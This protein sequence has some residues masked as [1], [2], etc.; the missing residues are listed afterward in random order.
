MPDLEITLTLIGGPTLLIELA[1][2]GILTHPTFDPPSLA[3]RSNSAPDVFT[4]P[5]YSPPPVFGI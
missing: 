5:E 2:L 3:V 4:S 1:G